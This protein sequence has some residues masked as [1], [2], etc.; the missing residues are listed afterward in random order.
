MKHSPHNNLPYTTSQMQTL[1]RIK[2]SLATEA[3]ERASKRRRA[4]SP[5][6]DRIQ[7]TAAATTAFSSLDQMFHDLAPE[8]EPFP[9]I[10]WEVEDDCS[11]ASC[12]SSSQ[13]PKN[14]SSV[15]TEYIYLAAAAG[16]KRPRNGAAR[17]VRSK[18][19]TCDLAGACR[20]DTLPILRS[21]EAP[22]IV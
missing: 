3:L 5:V 2:T 1:T 17:L 12:T 18:S 11:D 10:A 20:I 21:A 16:N 13:E 8:E 9:V 15:S 19:F 4:V 6:V 7:Q 14:S 22:C